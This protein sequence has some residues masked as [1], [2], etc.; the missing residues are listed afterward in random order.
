MAKRAFERLRVHKEKVV[1]N[2]QLMRG[3]NVSELRNVLERA[4]N[5]SKGVL[6]VHYHRT[7]H[8]VRMLDALASDHK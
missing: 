4:V 3:F 7:N 1:R 5:R 6:F 2:V 8:M